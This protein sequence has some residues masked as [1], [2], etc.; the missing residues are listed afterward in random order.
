MRYAF[1]GTPEFAATILEKLI[2]AR[3]S[4]VAVVC[5]PDR[6][7]GRKKVITPPP[8]KLLAQKHNIPVLQP[9]VLSTSNLEHQTSNCDFFLVAAYAKII[10]KEI[11]EIPWLGTVGVHPSLLPKYRGA[12]PIQT[13][14]L[15][16][17]KETGVTI[18]LVD[19][20]VDHGPIVKSQML[21]VRDQTYEALMRELAELAGDMLVETLPIFA[22]GKIQAVPQDETQ[23]TYTKKL[24]TDDAYV[25]PGDLEKALSGDSEITAAIS[26]KIRALNPEPGVWTRAEAFAN[27]HEY[28]LRIDTNKRVK[29][30]E[31]EIINGKLVLKKI[32]VEGK[33]PITPP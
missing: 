13:V 1:F 18:Y 14:I 2:K 3:M 32:Q 10:P 26:R 31:A 4:P 21:E 8:T 11:L 17:E 15:N 12:T 29:L 5:N 28:G 30:L 6:P 25:A 24:T 7:V 9:E 20:K 23:A 22:N 33:K 19:E 27:H 16:S